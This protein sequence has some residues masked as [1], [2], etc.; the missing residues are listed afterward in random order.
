MDI[1]FTTDEDPNDESFEIESDDDS[2]R[3]SVPPPPF[4]CSRAIQAVTVPQKVCFMDLTQLDRFIVQLNGMRMCATPGCKG[5]LIPIKAST[6]RLGEAVSIKYNC[7]GCG[8]HEAHFETSSQGGLY[9]TSEIMSVQVAFIV[10]GCT[11]ATYYKRVLALMPF[12]RLP[13]S[14]P[15]N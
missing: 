9:N 7:N 13:F 1:S 8:K 6:F 5:K 12:G 14:Q 2:I 4:R 11:H 10:A 15:L 3:P